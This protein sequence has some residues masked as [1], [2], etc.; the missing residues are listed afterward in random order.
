MSLHLF[1]KVKTAASVPEKENHQSKYK[2]KEK[3]RKRVRD[4]CLV[5]KKKH[6]DRRKNRENSMKAAKDYEFWVLKK[7]MRQQDST[8]CHMRMIFLGLEKLPKLGGKNICLIKTGKKQLVL[9]S[10][11]FDYETRQQKIW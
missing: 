11:V 2:E 1:S 7:R 9:I 8:S 10:I 4:L 3:E 6:K 5:P